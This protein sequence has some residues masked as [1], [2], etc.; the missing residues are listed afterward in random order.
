MPE[1]GP[2]PVR[3]GDRE[4]DEAAAERDGVA[5]GAAERD[6]GGR[7]AERVPVEDRRS[8]QAGLGDEPV[9]LVP[10][11][12]HVFPEQRPQA[13]ATDLQGRETRARAPR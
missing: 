3:I 5:A 12:R 2:E 11:L 6:S 1:D 8:P 9:E 10:H 4:D 7:G 13:A